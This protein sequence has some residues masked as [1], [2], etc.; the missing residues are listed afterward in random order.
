M[1]SPKAFYF[2]GDYN[3][4]VSRL[5]IFLGIFGAL[6][7]LYGLIQANELYYVIGAVFLLITAIY[8]NLTYFVALELI[9]LAGHG[10][11]LFDMGLVLQVVLPIFLSIQLFFYFLFTGEL[12]QNIFRL[13]GLLGVCILSVGFAYSNEWMYFFGSLGVTIY[14][15]YKV[16][17]KVYI[18][19]IWAILNLIFAVS[20]LFVLEFI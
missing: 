4:K 19:L 2:T 13:I 14:A 11:S 5:F 7:I 18:A 10:A 20:S 8:F 9:L 12:F 16:Y 17:N 3:T 6:I 1:P 15:F